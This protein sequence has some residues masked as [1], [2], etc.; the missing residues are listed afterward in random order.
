MLVPSSFDPPWPPPGRPGGSGQVRSVGVWEM[1]GVD[2]E[3]RLTK[4]RQNLNGLGCGFSTDQLLAHSPPP[5][6][7]RGIINLNSVLSPLVEKLKK[8]KRLFL[9]ILCYGPPHAPP[10]PPP[11]LGV[12]GGRLGEFTVCIEKQK[13]TKNGQMATVRV[14]MSERVKWKRSQKLLGQLHYRWPSKNFFSAS[15]MGPRGML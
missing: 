5:L 11:P 14:K 4:L 13:T 12:G 7:A 6:R 15:K 2:W 3:E 10:T 1:E 9:A 8:A